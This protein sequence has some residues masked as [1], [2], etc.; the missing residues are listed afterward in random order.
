MPQ[1]QGWGV[2]W[3]VLRNLRLNHSQDP[4]P[5]P[6]T[7]LL[8]VTTCITTPVSGCNQILGTYH[9]RRTEEKCAQPYPFQRDRQGR[10]I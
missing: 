4:G 10:E 7:P 9:L 3:G 8:P 2:L 1:G 6:L 5:G